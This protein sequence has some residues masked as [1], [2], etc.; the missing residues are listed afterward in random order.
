MKPIAISIIKEPMKSF[1]GMNPG[2]EWQGVKDPAAHSD[3]F[4]FKRLKFAFLLEKGLCLFELVMGQLVKAQESESQSGSSQDDITI[5][6]IPL[7]PCGIDNQAK[8][9]ALQNFQ[10]SL[11]LSLHLLGGEYLK[12]PARQDEPLLTP[13]FMAG[14]PGVNV[15]SDSNSKGSDKESSS[16]KIS[17]LSGKEDAENH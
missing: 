2:G 4:N 1:N 14:C 6:A 8:M 11:S 12:L 5:G 13:L 3:A 16:R 9:G 7:R 17:K 10:L 15:E